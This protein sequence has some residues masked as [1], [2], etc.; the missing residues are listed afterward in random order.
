MIDLSALRKCPDK[1]FSNLSLRNYNLDQDFWQSL[2]QN[3][4]SLQTD[5]ENLRADRKNCAKR[6]AMA[7]KAGEDSHELMEEAKAINDKISFFE[8]E[9]E[10]CK[11]KLKE[12]LLDIPNMLHTSVPPGEGERDNV[13]VRSVGKIPEFSFEP[14]DHTILG[15]GMGGMDFERAAHIASSRF[16]ILRGELAKFQ[17]ALA[18]FMLDL[19]VEKH[20]Y[21]EVYVPFLVN[22][23]SVTGTGQLPKFE[24][25]LFFSAQDALY[26]IPTAEVP[27][28]NMVSSSIVDEDMLPMKFVCHS[29]CFRR[30]AG[31]YGRDVKGMLRQHQFEKVELVHVVT[32]ETSYDALEEMTQHAEKVLQLLELPYRVVSLCS[33]DIGFAA[34]KTYDL[35]VWLPSQ[36]NYREISSCSNCEA[37][38]ARRMKARYR[39]GKGTVS[40]VHTL[41][42]SGIAVGRALVACLENYQQSDGGIR[43]PKALQPYLKG[44]KLIAAMSDA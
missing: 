37:F 42:G 24:N 2:E 14:K 31:S 13:V 36:E 27:L 40:F 34:A 29:P 18:Q 8:K 15:Q 21:Q 19:H 16:V 38:Q 7:K 5:I 30:E 3:R 33:G 6:I 25:D 1:I 4:K 28:T 35:E 12:F 20:G 39:D 17:R 32:P 43:V 23:S 41:N 11:Q 22:S 44:Q 26:L 9:Y 10:L